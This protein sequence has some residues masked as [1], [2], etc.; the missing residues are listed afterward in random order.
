[1]AGYDGYSMSNNAREAYEDGYMPKSKWTKATMIEAIKTYIEENL[2]DDEWNFSIDKL[3][4]MSRELLFNTFFI[5][6]EWHHT[7]SKYNRTD[8][9]GVN[10]FDVVNMTDEKIDRLISEDKE[11]R[12]SRREK[13]QEKPEEPQGM[14]LC[15]FKHWTGTKKHPKCEIVQTVG[16][17][18]GKMFYSSEYGN[19]RLSADGFRILSKADERVR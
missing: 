17:I 11:R 5:Y 3:N 18:K 14:Y 1:M 9:Y 13:K 6:K 12:A 16:E 2:L 15:E 7:S 4:G 10:E 19:K 8:F